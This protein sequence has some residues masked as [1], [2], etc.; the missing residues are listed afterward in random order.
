[1]NYRFCRWRIYF[2]DKIKKKKFL[3]YIYDNIYILKTQSNGAPLRG[4]TF[5]PPELRFIFYSFC[6][7]LT[8][9]TKINK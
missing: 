7:P 5:V 4:A 6:P 2:Y 9:G 1:M 8:G 3:I